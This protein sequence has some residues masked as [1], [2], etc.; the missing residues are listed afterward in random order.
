ME[1]QL[2]QVSASVAEMQGIM[3]SMEE[4]VGLSVDRKLDVLAERL[5]GDMR[6][7]LKEEMQ[8]G[9]KE[10]CCTINCNGL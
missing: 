1:T 10:I 9:I 4:K 5:K 3:D 6:M 7:Q 8:E 2:Q